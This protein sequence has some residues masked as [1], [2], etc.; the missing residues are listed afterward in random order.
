MADPAEALALA[1]GGLAV[2]I[3]FSA[4]CLPGGGM[5]C[6]LAVGLPAAAAAVPHELAHK[7]VAERLGCRARYVL[8]PAGLALTLATSLPQVPVKFVMPGITVVSAPLMDP[9]EERRLEGLVS[10]SGPAYNIAASL[11][12]AALAALPGLGPGP[13]AALSFSAYVNSWVALFNLLP[14]PP[15]DGSKALR[16][17]P[18]PYLAFLLLAAALFLYSL[19]A[20]G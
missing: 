13:R 12:S 9:A 4:Q 10:L 11:A 19:G 20:P 18:G 8:H 5:A 16:W 2:A 6:L 15:L 1:V 3:A 14:L 7:W 17:R